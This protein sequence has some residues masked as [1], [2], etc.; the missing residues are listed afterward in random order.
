MLKSLGFDCYRDLAI[1]IQPS[2]CY[3]GSKC[4]LLQL[5]AAE[6]AQTKRASVLTRAARRRNG[7]RLFWRLGSNGRART[8]TNKKAFVL[9]QRLVHV[10]WN[11]VS[12]A[13]LFRLH[14]HLFTDKR[15]DLTAQ[16]CW[17]STEKC[18]RAEKR[19]CMNKGMKNRHWMK[20]ANRIILLHPL[21]ST[22]QKGCTMHQQRNISAPVKPSECCVFEPVPVYGLQL[23][24]VECSLAWNKGL[25]R[26]Y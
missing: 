24:S 19:F 17:K 6:C 13:W 23:C 21:P 9:H 15:L 8:A 7:T 4:V 12:S 11:C 20:C 10:N 18:L 22:N 5:I 3:A 2:F 25:K 16:E 14:S 26:N 1:C